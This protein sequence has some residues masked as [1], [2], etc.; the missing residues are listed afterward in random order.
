MM[1][2]E[3]ILRRR[4]LIASRNF[5]SLLL[6]SVLVLV[7]VGCTVEKRASGSDTIAV[8]GRASRLAGTRSAPVSR[9]SLT[10][11]TAADLEQLLFSQDAP[12]EF[13]QEYWALGRRIYDARRYAPLWIGSEATDEERQIRFGLLCRAQDEGI[14]LTLLPAGPSATK[15]AYNNRRVDST[16]RRDLRLTFALTQYLTMRARGSVTPSAVGAEWNV[17]PPARPSDATL[18]ALIET[19]DSVGIAHLMPPSPQYALLSRALKHLLDI[20]SRGGWSDLADSV[21]LAPGSRGP[22]VERLRKRLVLSGDIAAADSVGASYTAAVTRGVRKFQRR[23]GLAQDGHVGSATRAELEV[24]AQARARTV[25]ANLERYRWLPR[26]LIG[27]IV[28]LDLAGESMQVSRNGMPVLTT[29]I[30]VTPN[31]RMRIPPVIADTIA[32]IS[33]SDAAIGMHLA[34]GDSVT[35]RGNASHGEGAACLIADNL[36]G[37]RTVLTVPGV[38]GSSATVL[39]LI[40]PTAYVAGDSTLMYRHDATGADARIGASLPAP[41]VNDSAICERR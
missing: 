26:T 1:V 41:R 38:P 18:A 21:P 27:Q 22:A 39:Y 7:T 10:Q 34:K 6:A 2:R 36:A 35:I 3:I 4:P 17:A 37:L 20:Q 9:D 32:R 19:A 5:V 25:A 15:P 23:V 31:C 14:V 28:I 30:H 33:A 12:S 24:T 16:A 40:W 29:T 8:P 11:A 13:S